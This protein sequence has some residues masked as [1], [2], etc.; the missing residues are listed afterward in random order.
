M[1]SSGNRLLNDERRRRLIEAVRT[2]IQQS[3][4]TLTLP[5]STESP[6]PAAPADPGILHSSQDFPGLHFARPNDLGDLRCA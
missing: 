1:T 3:D 4:G 6:L 2:A 5:Q